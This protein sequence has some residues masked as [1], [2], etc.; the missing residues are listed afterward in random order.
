MNKTDVRREPS[1]ARTARPTKVLTSGPNLSAFKST[2][3][4]TWALFSGL[5]LVMMGNGLNGSLLGVRSEAEGFGL[6]VGGIVMACYF[7]GFL[8]GSHYATH[9]LGTVGHIRVFAALASTASTTVLL[10]ATFV[11]PVV[12]GA[13]RFLFG[14]CMAGL[15]VVVESWLNHMATNE[16]RG[17][18][19][20]IYMVISMGG[21]SIGQALLTVADTNGFGLFILASVLVSMSLVPVSL[22]STSAPPLGLPEPM[23]IRAIAEIVPTGLVTAFFVGAGAGTLLGIGAIY[24]ATVDMPPSRIALFLSAPMIGAM[25]AQLPIG[26][27][28]DRIS[29]RTVILVVSALAAAVSAGPLFVDPNSLWAIGFM[30]LLGALTFPLYSLGIAYTNDWLPAEKILGASGALVRVNGTGAVIGPVVT[31]ILMALLSARL[32]FWG[33]VVAHLAIVVYVIFRIAVIEAPDVDRQRD[34][35]VIPFRSSSAVALLHPRRRRLRG[36]PKPVRRRKR[37][38]D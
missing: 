26:M 36:I 24:G 21:V 18:L 14:L 22:S 27:L 29:R 32:F 34:F 9:V 30:F 28:S 38:P 25:I 4:A 20:S 13:M 35:V 15:Y 1:R 11:N 23:S 8:A 31:A 33:L 37:P 12:W 7:A 3:A 2:A 19:L 5:A 17:R 10:H 16:T 6:A